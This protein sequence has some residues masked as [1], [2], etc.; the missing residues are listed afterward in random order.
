MDVRNYLPGVFVSRVQTLHPRFVREFL[1]TR[2]LGG[3]YGEK[4]QKKNRVINDTFRPSSFSTS[5]WHNTV[6]M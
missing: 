5:L 4:S 1:H 2:G 3:I 6:G